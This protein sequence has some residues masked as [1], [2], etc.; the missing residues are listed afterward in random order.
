[1]SLDDADLPDGWRVWNEEREGR[2]ILV[3][4]PDVFDADAFD[5]AC[6][7]TLYVTNGSRRARPGSGQY[8]T[9][10]WHATLFLE[11]EVE[12]ES[13][14]YDER[15]AALDGAREAAARFARGEVDYRGA[16]QVPREEYFEA[17]DDLTGRKA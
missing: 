14:R 7:P 12:V 9:D 3:Y 15:D 11:P 16:Y 13:T 1:M 6:L 17:L 5:P 2:V 4:R 8:E 10:E